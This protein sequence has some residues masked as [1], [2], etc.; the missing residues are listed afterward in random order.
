[1]ILLTGFEPFD[2][3]TT[4]PSIQAARAAA[5]A[6]QASG[7]EAVAVELPC[8]FA[9]APV[10]LER[11]IARYSPDVVLCTGLAG[12]RAAVSLERVALN[13]I[14]ARI[15]DNAGDQPIDEP[16]EPGGP[17]ARWSTLP[18]KRALVL[19][20]ED[21][22]AA[23]LSLSAGSY[24]CNQVF[25]ALMGL[26]PAGGP[27]RGGFIHLPPEG[28]GG[29]GNRAAARALEIIALT[30][31]DPEPDMHYAAGTEY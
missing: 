23:E 15:P 25:Y 1:M 6:L 10:A 22:L 31:L 21:G 30:A 13:L 28:A 12:G 29:I 24:V 27:V 11:A 5:T 26:L 14:D 17:A 20:R 4:N 3:A 7:H 19:L 8:V 16:V 18:L 9:T 2:G